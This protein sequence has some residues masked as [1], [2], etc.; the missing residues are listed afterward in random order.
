VVLVGVR[1]GRPEPCRLGRRSAAHG[2]AGTRA[3][4]SAC[5]SRSERRSDD[6]G[7]ARVGKLPR[8]HDVEDFDAPD[9]SR[10]EP[11]HAVL[12]AEQATACIGPARWGR[13]TT[14][15]S[16]TR[17]L[18]HLLRRRRPHACDQAGSIV[19]IRSVITVLG[20]GAVGGLLAALLERAGNDA[21][22]LARPSTARLIEDRGLT[23]R[24]V[25]FGDFTVRPSTLTRLKSDYDDVLI[26]ATK[27]SDL[28]AAIARVN[29]TPSLVLPLLNGIEHMPVLRARFGAQVIAGTITVESDRPEPGVIVHSS[30]LLRIQITS[31]SP[32]QREA[33]RSLA[34]SLNVAGIDTAVSGS[35]PQVLWS[36]LVRLNALACTT[37][38]S[39]LLLGAI[40]DD[41]TWWA[42]LKRAVVETAAVARA[43][44]APVDPSLALNDLACLE[45]GQGSSM[46][47]DI[48]AGRESELDAIPGAVLR[49]ARR[50]GIVV[51][52]IEAL[53]AEVAKRAGVAP[54]HW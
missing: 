42:R 38:A 5:T 18:P 30:R 3:S 31:P 52:T 39:G 24:S 43:E 13:P 53:V 2:R 35:E 44:R 40:R 51:P 33:V 54:P 4:R 1:S 10:A 41:P 36:K 15:S 9:P 20:P 47:R 28:D 48:A 49:A 46:A 11:R 16:H 34:A 8:P 21:R 17:R 29:S 25:T 12:I 26:V 19:G 22:V 23:L 7:R 27:S 32:K 14:A 37:S 45:P 50:H 6:G